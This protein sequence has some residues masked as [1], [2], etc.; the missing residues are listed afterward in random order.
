MNVEVA[1]MHPDDAT[2]VRAPV[3][4]DEGEGA[5]GGGGA[6]ESRAGAHQPDNSLVTPIVSRLERWLQSGGS[7]GT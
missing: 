4:A 2:G 7:S 3:F 5:G 1:P 6:T